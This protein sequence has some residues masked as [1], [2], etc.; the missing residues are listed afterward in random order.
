M[1]KKILIIAVAVLTAVA[2]LTL[3]ACDLGVNVDGGD[4]NIA[5]D[6]NSE[7]TERNVDNMRSGAGYYLRYSLK[8]HSSE[9]G[10]TADEEIV[11]AAKGDVYYVKATD[12]EE[13]YYDLSNEAY[14]VLYNKDGA[15]AEWTKTIS[16]YDE[17]YTKADATA[18][19]K[20][21]FSVAGLYMT[22]YGS[23]QGEAAFSDGMKKESATVAGRS[24]DKYGW[25]VNMN[26]GL[27]SMNYHYDCYIDKTTGI[28]LKWTFSG[29]ASVVGE[30]SGSGSVNFECKEFRQSW[31]PTFPQVSEENTHVN[32]E[33]QAETGEEGDEIED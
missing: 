26:L 11:V 21:Q 7:A 12:G 20:L 27:A 28:C 23:A 4:A 17:D 33:P 3:V 13:A 5:D 1:K 8:G 24:C 2:L 6:Y 29:E 14:L 15:E 30:G 22:Y 32:N 31:T 19:A 18:E 16:Y 10:Q 25:G 9:D